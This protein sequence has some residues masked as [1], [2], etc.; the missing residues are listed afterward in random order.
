MVADNWQVDV[1][2]G[3]YKE[4]GTWFMDKWLPA[5]NINSNTKVI[6]QTQENDR[7]SSDKLQMMNLI[8]L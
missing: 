3:E 1:D 6:K 7:I 2:E 4:G 5:K 8:T